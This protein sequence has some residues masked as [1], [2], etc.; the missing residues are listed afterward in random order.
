MNKDELIETLKDI[1]WGI[2]TTSMDYWSDKGKEAE[3]LDK[4]IELI[5]R[6]DDMNDLMVRMFEKLEVV[7]EEADKWKKFL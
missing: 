3:A 4:A 2:G 6:M 1:R 7:K 5:E